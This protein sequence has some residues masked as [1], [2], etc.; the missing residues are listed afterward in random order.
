MLKEV[1]QT[2]EEIKGGRVK[3][4]VRGK[5]NLLTKY[6]SMINL[7]FLVKELWMLPMLLSK[8]KDCFEKDCKPPMSL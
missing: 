8:S 3:T 1:L 5:K 6:L 4:Q 7:A 2:L